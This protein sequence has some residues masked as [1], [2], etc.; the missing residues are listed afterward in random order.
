MQ[1]TDVRYLR[2]E[3]EEYRALAQSLPEG[4]CWHTVALEKKL[5]RQAENIGWV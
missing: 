4:G 2:R 1:L 5:L 3:L